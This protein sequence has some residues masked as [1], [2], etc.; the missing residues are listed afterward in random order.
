MKYDAIANAYVSLTESMMSEEFLVESRVDYVKNN[1]AHKITTKHDTTGD[2]KDPEEIIDHFAKHADPSKNK[3]YTG[4]ITNQ[5]I[6]QKI[7]QEDHPRIHSVLSNFE[8]YKGKLPEKDINKYHSL[9]DINTAVK[10]HIGTASTNKEKEA[11]VEHKGHELKHEDERI[12]IYHLKDADASKQIYGGGANCGKTGTDWCTAA[13]SD[14]NMFDKYNEAGKMHVIHD[15][16]NGNLYQYHPASASFMDRNDEPI[17]PK[18]FQEL[19]PHIHAAW[20]K[21]PSLVE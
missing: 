6:G 5:Y 1:F 4:W 11:D 10:P 16:K 12:K 7:R 15:K 13:R 14:N 8:K 3:Q 9:V 20:K 17:T 19:A 21:N 2:L 18:D